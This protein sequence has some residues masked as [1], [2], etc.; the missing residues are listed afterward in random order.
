MDKELPSFSNGI[1][2]KFNFL[3]LL[4]DAL[5]KPGSKVN[6]EHKPK[7][8]FLLAYTASVYELPKKGS[9]QRQ[10]NKD[11][12]KATQ[13]AIEKV[14]NICSGGKS[15]MELIAEINTLYSCIRYIFL[16]F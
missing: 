15:V 16:I 9:R 4:I 8:I 1:D 14:H 6:P 12:L 11:D 13:T 3:E 5:F 10:V 2:N 7:Y